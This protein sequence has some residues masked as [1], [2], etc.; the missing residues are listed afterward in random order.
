MLGMSNEQLIGL[1]RQILPVFGGIAVTL[2]WFT[3]DQVV[4]G[5]STILQIIGPVMIVGSSIWSLVSKTKANL[6]SAVSA[7]P[8]VQS[9]KLQPTVAGAALAKDTPANVS[10][11]VPGPAPMSKVIGL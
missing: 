1:L 10:T 8:E 6:V 11:T 3:S 4:A 2:G 9:I 5:T 7:M